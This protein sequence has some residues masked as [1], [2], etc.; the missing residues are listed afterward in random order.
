V[1]FSN[2]ASRQSD[3]SERHATL[4]VGGGW[5]EKS[6]SGNPSIKLSMLTIPSSLAEICT[7]WGRYRAGKAS[8]KSQVTNF[9]HF[10]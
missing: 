10:R 4:A 3:E 1:D 5:G 2:S 8:K 7:V 6:P 9:A